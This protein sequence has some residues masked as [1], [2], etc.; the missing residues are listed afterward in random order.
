MYFVFVSENLRVIPNLLKTY[1]MSDGI[2]VVENHFVVYLI[3]YV[4]KHKKKIP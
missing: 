3:Q 1:Q 4:H 2:M